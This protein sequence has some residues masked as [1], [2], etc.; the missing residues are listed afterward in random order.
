MINAEE[1]TFL[2]SEIDLK[3][4]I[5]NQN[6]QESRYFN[7]F[8]STYKKEW[9]F[10]FDKDMDENMFYN[11]NFYALTYRYYHIDKYFYNEKNKSVVLLHKALMPLDI[12]AHFKKT[13]VSK[14]LDFVY[15]EAP[16]SIIKK[17]NDEYLSL[18]PDSK[19]L[20]YLIK[21][22]DIDSTNVNDVQLVDKN[23][24][25]T[26]LNDV[27]KSLYGKEIILIVWAFW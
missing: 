3:K 19:L 25:T 16:W 22:Y 24:K 27:L 10:Q 7:S 17:N 8:R 6:I 9:E 26:T 13:V 15:S 5:V 12:D 1:Y 21:K 20:K 18:Y 2:K 14:F 23:G 4:Y 11:P